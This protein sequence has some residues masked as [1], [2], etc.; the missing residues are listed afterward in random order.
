MS[1]TLIIII[2]PIIALIF[3]LI[4]A[5]LIWNEPSLKDLTGRYIYAKRGNSYILKVEYYIDESNTNY[6]TAT[7]DDIRIL[8]E[9][10]ILE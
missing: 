8:K 7:K 1:N 3:I 9:A 4:L 6:R 5:N 10:N 2:I